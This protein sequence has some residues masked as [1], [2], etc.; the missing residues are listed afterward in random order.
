MDVALGIDTTPINIILAILSISL[1]FC[2]I[3]ILR[4]FL[5]T[6]KTYIKIV[7]LLKINK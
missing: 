5:P 4:L 7:S 2:V 6:R 1:I 3:W